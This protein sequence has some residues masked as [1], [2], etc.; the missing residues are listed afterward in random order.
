MMVCLKVTMHYFRLVGTSVLFLLCMMATLALAQNQPATGTWTFA[1][2][3]DS[4][5]CGD[6]VM[7]AIA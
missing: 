1:V 5:N 4:R 2:S 6:I 7:P 3:G